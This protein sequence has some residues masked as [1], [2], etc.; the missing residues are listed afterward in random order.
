VFSHT[1]F[2][3]H[4]NQHNDTQHNDTKHNDTQHNDTQH[5][6][7]QHNDTQHNET[8]PNDTQCRYLLLGRLSMV[9]LLI[10]IGCLAK[11]YLVS[12]CKANDLNC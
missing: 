4:D 5:N 8:E 7:T 6:D 1:F 11:K 10:K 2:R 3:R 12:V 9:D